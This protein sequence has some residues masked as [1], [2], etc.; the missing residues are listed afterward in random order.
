MIVVTVLNAKSNRLKLLTRD[1]HFYSHSVIFKHKI[2]VI[3]MLI[4]F[5]ALILFSVYLPE[6][7]K[8]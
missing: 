2:A 1:F 6:L 8:A 7:Q 4:F 5:Q 3:N